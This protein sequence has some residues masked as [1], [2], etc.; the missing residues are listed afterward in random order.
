MLDQ[1]ILRNLALFIVL[2]AIPASAADSGPV[3]AVT[4]GR[5]RG[6]VL[7]N[8][9]A[10]FKGIPF[11]APPVGDLRWREPMPVNPWGGVRD[12]TKFGA[13]C[14]QNPYFISD[15]KEVSREDCLFLN[16]WSPEWPSRSRKPVMVWI[17]GGGNFGGASGQGVN[18]GQNLARHGV[19][20]VTINY[21][22]GLFG[23]FAHPELTRE[24]PHHAS[25][26][27]GILDQ[28]A[29]L[30]W[31][32]QNIA[33]FGGDPANVTIFGE[34]AGSL[35][36]SVLMTSPLSKGLFRHVIGESGAVILVGD[37]LTLVQAEKQGESFA[38]QWNIG[39]ASLKGMRAVP[40]AGI[41]KK[42]PDYLQ[43][44]PPNLGITIDGYVFPRRPADVFAAGQEHPVDLLLGNNSRERIPGTTPPSDLTKAVE[45]T[46]GPIAKQALAIYVGAADPLYGMPADQWATDTSFRC[47]AVLQL[48]WHAAA[49]NA[50]FEFQF[51]RTPPGRESVGATHNSDLEYVFDTF[52]SRTPTPAPHYDAVDQSVSDAMQQ[53]WTNFAK[54]GDPSGGKLPQWPKF[55]PVSRT[56]MEFT[57]AGPVTREGLRRPFCD[58][59]I[60]NA[61]RQMGK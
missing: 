9:G 18:N 48:M 27:Q 13:P 30:R 25:G 16:I 10:V 57:G 6:A 7:P 59:F 20:V 42:E 37:P 12:A 35:D 31:V 46:Y 11:A 23:F 44:P 34:S 32:R 40:A 3:V 39:D 22:L 60:E 21:R 29:A 26:N 14:A 58:L 15:A 51:D 54:T 47:S 61:K 1:P 19:V 41:L 38:Q 28:I 43:S 50:A 4:G 5:I 56:Y 52:G 53:Y 8:S 55:D 2:A 36:V 17:P 33:R 49:G 24:S 45:D